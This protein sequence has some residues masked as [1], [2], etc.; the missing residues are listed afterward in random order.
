MSASDIAFNKGWFLE[1]CVGLQTGDLTYG[2]KAMQTPVA[3]KLEADVHMLVPKT[4]QTVWKRAI[5]KSNEMCL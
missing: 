3:V 4:M 2:G 5:F 1:R